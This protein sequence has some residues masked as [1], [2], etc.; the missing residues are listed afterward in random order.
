MELLEKLSQ[1]DG[2]F[3]FSFYQSIS[4]FCPEKYCI[5]EREQE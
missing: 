5:S 4:F 2:F 1:K 3:Y